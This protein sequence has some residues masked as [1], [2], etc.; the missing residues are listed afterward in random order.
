MYIPTYIYALTIYCS[1]LF[2]MICLCFLEKIFRI[3]L[4]SYCQG[5]L[6]GWLFEAYPNIHTCTEDYI[7]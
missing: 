7:L 4:E 6:V 1:I 3:V 2:Q 5:G